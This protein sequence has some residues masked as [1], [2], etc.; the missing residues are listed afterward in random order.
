MRQPTEKVN[1][2]KGNVVTFCSD[3][4]LPMFWEKNLLIVTFCSDKFLVL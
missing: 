3:K 2:S 4:F 1:L